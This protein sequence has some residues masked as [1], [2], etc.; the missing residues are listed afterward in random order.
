MGGIETMNNHYN[1]F[2]FINMV[3]S[4]FLGVLGPILALLGPNFGVTNYW[5]CL[6]L[7]YMD[8]VGW[9]IWG[10]KQKLAF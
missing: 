2:S 1:P 6:K 5:G 4:P 9:K 7:L 3:I 10:W 8:L